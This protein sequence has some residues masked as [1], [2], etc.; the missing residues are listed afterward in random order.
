MEQLESISTPIR[1]IRAGWRTKNKIYPYL[2][3]QQLN[4]T[5][6][7]DKIYE[8]PL[9]E[10]LKLSLVK[11][12]EKFCIGYEPSQGSWLVCPDQTQLLISSVNQCESCQKTDFFSCRVTCQGIQC[13]P[14]SLEAKALCDTNETSLYLTYIGGIFK[15]NSYQKDIFKVGVSLNPLR[16]WIEQGSFYSTVLWKGTGLKTRYYEHQLG[17]QL[18]LRLSV[19]QKI[20]L[21]QIGKNHPN[22]RDIH[23]KFEKILEKISNSKLISLESSYNK[24]TNL[25]KY[26][27]GIPNITRQAIVDNDQISG[28][29]IGVRGSILVL[30][31][32]NSYYAVNLKKIVGHILT[33]LE[34]KSKKPRQRTL[35][36]F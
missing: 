8:L 32:R 7:Y 4:K 29:I 17:Q 31:D 2:A 13:N 1:V 18:D 19:Q 6:F 28:K 3:Y 15:G 14:K 34:T 11:S 30:Q 20:K 25:N 27:G 23:S 35:F 10:N 12:E 36:D 21:K 24:I 22:E 26:Y 9:I 33:P 16:R 5:K